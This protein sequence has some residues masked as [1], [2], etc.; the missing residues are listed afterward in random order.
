M[1]QYV[2]KKRYKFV[3]NSIIIYCI[4]LFTSKEC[5]VGVGID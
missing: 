3:K 1:K 4:H 2:L 5:I